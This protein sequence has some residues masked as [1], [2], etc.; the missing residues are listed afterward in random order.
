MAA[1]RVRLSDAGPAPKI[2]DEPP[3]WPIK[4]EFEQVQ[5]AVLEATRWGKTALL[6]CNGC[7]FEV[8]SFF[9]ARDCVHIDA[10]WILNGTGL[11]KPKDVTEIQQEL[12]RQ[13]IAGV[14]G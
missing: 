8:D 14:N 13:V 10:K 1:A 11:K 2:I 4:V 3:A 9:L 12:H 5:K 7:A 6:V